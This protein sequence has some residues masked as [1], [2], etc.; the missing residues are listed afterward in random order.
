[1]KYNLK[2]LIIDDHYLIRKGV[3]LMLEQQNEFIPKMSEAST[4]KESLAIIQT[5]IFDLIIL[6]I[7]LNDM[8]GLD[9]L[10]EINILAPT[11]PVLI[12]SMHK[13]I[14]IINQA[15]DLQIA[16]YI[17]KSAEKN[18]LIDAVSS[19]RNQNTYFSN[20][21]HQILNPIASDKNGL[22]KKNDDSLLSRREK[23]IL[24]LL[25]KEMTSQVIAEFLYISK[26]TV[27]W[28]RKVI[29]KKLGVKTTIGLVKFAMKYHI[30]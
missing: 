10:R 28:H 8:N 2:V 25:A 11:T 9:V 12:Q 1:M 16:G 17:L 20:E 23:E 15:V 18:E 5:E 26:R 13:E 27:E 4:G 24:S 7:S 3:A 19:I 6:D 29:M 21:I 22:S 30:E 14:N